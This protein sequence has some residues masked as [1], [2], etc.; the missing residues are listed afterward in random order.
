MLQ[1]FKS[2][3]LGNG[4]AHS[5]IINL[6]LV[7][8]SLVGEEML[9]SAVT[10]PFFS[11]LRKK[12]SDRG[13]LVVASVIGAVLFGSMHLVM[14]DF[15]IYQCIVTIG[16]TRLPFTWLWFKADNLKPAI[17]AHR[18]YDWIILFQ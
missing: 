13:A 16:L 3:P 1:Y 7:T 11:L 15:N 8:I 17:V 5:K 6:A 9:T 18:V 4:D 10:M 12:F 14:Y 2:T